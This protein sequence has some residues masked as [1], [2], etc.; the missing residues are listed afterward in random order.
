M[1]GHVGE[2]ALALW[3]VGVVAVQTLRLLFGW[4]ILKPEGRLISQ[5][6]CM[7]G[8]SVMSGII[9]GSTAF[10]LQ[11]DAALEVMVAV[12]FVLA[13]MSAAA[14]V[15]L[16]GSLPSF[17]GFIVPALVPYIVVQAG[18]SEPSSNLFAFVALVYLLSISL[19]GIQLHR[20]VI[21]SVSLAE[22]NR[23][24]AHQ[25]D[26]ARLRLEHRV[27]EREMELNT[28]LETVPA[29]IWI[30]HD[31]EARRV[32]RSA[33]AERRFREAAKGRNSRAVDISKNGVILA[34]DQ[35]PLALAARGTAVDSMELRFHFSDGNHIDQIISA[36]PL[37]DRD[38]SIIGA[39]GAGIDITSRKQAEEA[40]K[41]SESRFRDFA[42]SASDWLWETDADHRFVWIS[43]NIEQRIDVRADWYYGKTRWEILP[44]TVD[45]T[46][47]DEHKRLLDQRQPFR[48]FEYHQRGPKQDRWFSVSG[49]PIVNCDGSFKGYRGVAR[50]VTDRKAA[51]R[52]VAFLAHHDSLTDL[53]NRRLFQKTLREL[54]AETETEG[55]RLALIVV[56]IDHFK[57]VNDTHGHEAGDQLL[58]TIGERLQTCVGER[59]LFARVGGDEFA[60]VLGGLERASQARSVANAMLSAMAKPISVAGHTVFPSISIGGALFPDDAGD[61]DTLIQQADRALYRSKREG[62]N[63]CHFYDADLDRYWQ[64]QS[65]LTAELAD[66]IER[67]EFALH[68][69]PQVDLETGRTVAVEALLRWQHPARGIVMPSDFIPLAESNG[70]ICRIGAW[71]IDEACRQVNVWRTAG[72]DLSV[73]VNLSQPQLSDHDTL[74]I[75]DQALERHDL[76]AAA[77]ELEIT[78]TVVMDTTVNY[79]ADTISAYADRSLRLAL[80]D[81]GTGYSSLAYLRHLPAQTIKIDRSFVAD[82]GRSNGGE[83]LV[84]SIVDLA[85]TLD[86]SVVAEGVETEAQREFL[87]ARRC[88]TGQ[89]FLFGRPV[90]PE[91]LTLH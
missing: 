14:A 1:S 38:G 11:P 69:Q 91:E 26:D 3:S 71:V 40:L 67:N 83:A 13:G 25:L 60:A 41:I 4:Q 59:G 2:R 81:F 49:V 33:Y 10:W 84:G 79:G 32:I 70:L 77:L 63:R 62:R 9:W 28:L 46:V 75:I 72:H 74:R 7:I 27:A 89:G 31:P 6:N 21:G 17:Y 57:H 30:T 35:R 48:G 85:H 8:F 52:R 18:L 43:A 24:L 37:R 16:A 78:E 36:A 34:D 58:R 76:D 29:F 54:R 53:P 87:K 56:D 73:A 66:A 23:E 20:L 50:D 39:V 19:V 44:P 80:D 86:K 51:E 5:A 61:E 68:Y 42:T 90:R 47:L 15:S 65:Q 22:R 55:R 45:K 82:I 88:D 12:S 64:E